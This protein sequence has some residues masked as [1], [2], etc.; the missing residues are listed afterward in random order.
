MVVCKLGHVRIPDN[1]HELQN[2]T[3]SE[4]TI[5]CDCGEV[6]QHA[7]ERLQTSSAFHN[8]KSVAYLQ[9]QKFT[10]LDVNAECRSVES[11][12]LHILTLCALYKFQNDKYKSENVVHNCAK[13]IMLVS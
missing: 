3:N 8:Y 9:Q 13:G 11:N 1:G 2:N 7:D 10:K 6:S 12:T 4:V 5:H